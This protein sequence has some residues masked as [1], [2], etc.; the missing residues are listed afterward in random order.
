[1]KLRYLHRVSIHKS[2]P[3]CNFDVRLLGGG[4]FFSSLHKNTVEKCA[5]INPIGKKK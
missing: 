5:G 1:M 2:A 4:C 3:E